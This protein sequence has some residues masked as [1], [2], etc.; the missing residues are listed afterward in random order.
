MAGA[1]RGDETCSHVERQ[2]W[3][4]GTKPGKIDFLLGQPE[5]IRRAKRDARRGN[6]DEQRGRKSGGGLPFISRAGQAPGNYT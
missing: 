5:W 3:K 6:R 2:N 4:K 1:M